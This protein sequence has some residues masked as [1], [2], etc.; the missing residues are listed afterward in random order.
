MTIDPKDIESTSGT[1]I[2]G[3]EDGMIQTEEKYQAS[4]VMAETQEQDAERQEEMTEAIEAIEKYTQENSTGKVTIGTIVGGD[5]LQS[6]L[7][8]SLVL[9]FIMVAAL[10]LFYTYNR[11]QSQQDIIAIDNM[12]VELKEL[13]YKVLTQ[14]S[15]LVNLCRQSNVEKRLEATNDS[16]LKNPTTPP[17]LIRMSGDE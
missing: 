15:E 11:Y 2:Q 8:R 6:K 4:S 10:M 12:K 13:K 14:S 16:M 3:E 9:W 7:A 17:Y 5:L 1:E